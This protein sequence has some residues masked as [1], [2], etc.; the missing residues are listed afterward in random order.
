MDMIGARYT[1]V[2]SAVNACCINRLPFM[3]VAV[4]VV[5]TIVGGCVMNASNVV[6]L[7]LRSQHMFRV[8][9]CRAALPLLRPLLNPQLDVG[10]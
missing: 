4:Q 8:W 7:Y 10:Y 6:L 9:V 1:R 2:I 3:A 5:A